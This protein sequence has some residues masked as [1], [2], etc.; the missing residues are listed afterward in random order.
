M[1]RI[2]E[3]AQKEV[4]Y[5]GWQ[6]VH[7]CFSV[8]ISDHRAA[9]CPHS[10]LLPCSPGGAREGAEVSQWKSWQAAASRQLC[11]WQEEE[12]GKMPGLWGREDTHQGGEDKPREKLQHNPAQTTL[13][14]SHVLWCP[15]FSPPPSLWA[16]TSLSFLQCLI[17][18][19][20]VWNILFT[21]YRAPKL[22]SILQKLTWLVKL[23]LCFLI[24]SFNNFSDE[25]QTPAAEEGKHVKDRLELRVKFLASKAVRIVSRTFPHP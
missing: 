19:F 23:V 15:A 14:P 9:L 18:C 8:L 16:F 10:C 3:T 1:S 7:M 13:E 12:E 11:H 22:E 4:C 17:E 5:S 2:E 24:S 25:M 21:P 6:A 20:D